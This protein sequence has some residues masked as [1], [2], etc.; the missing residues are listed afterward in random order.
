MR[1]DE[2]VALTGTAL[3]VPGSFSVRIPP[4]AQRSVSRSVSSGKLELFQDFACS[5]VY[6]FLFLSKR[7]Q[8]QPQAQG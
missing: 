2:R 7:A 5:F 1:A 3:H 6:I 8:A 4:L